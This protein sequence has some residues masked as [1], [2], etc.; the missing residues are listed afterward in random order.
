MRRPNQKRRL[1]SLSLKHKTLNPR[2]TSS[3]SKRRLLKISHPLRSTKS[4][5]S[6]KLPLLPSK[7][8]NNSS[9]ASKSL[10]LTLPTRLVLLARRSRW[11]PWNSSRLRAK[12]PWTR[13]W[14]KPTSSRFWSLET[15][16]KVSQPS[17]TCS[18]EMNCRLSRREMRQGSHRRCYKSLILVIRRNRRPW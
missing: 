14:W 7:L 5:L 17:P 8:R 9:L 2:R 11:S 4:S 6:L 1:K 10:L 3:L 13:P 15:S 16:S 18:W 12:C